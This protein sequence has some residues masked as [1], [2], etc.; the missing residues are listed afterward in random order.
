MKKG[1]TVFVK[2]LS[3]GDINYEIA[4]LKHEVEKLKKDISDLE[5]TVKLI[6]GFLTPTQKLEV[7]K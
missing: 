3:H 4:I 2:E 7:D 1:E 5:N 6:Y